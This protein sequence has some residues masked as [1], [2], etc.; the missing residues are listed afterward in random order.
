MRPAW[1]RVIRMHRR[2]TSANGDALS[3]AVTY[4]AL[5]GGVPALILTT[6]ALSGLGADRDRTAVALHRAADRLLPPDVAHALD[7]LRPD[8]IGLRIALVVALVW[9]SLRMVRA[10]RT[11]VR[12]MCGQNAG[13]GN[14]VRDAVVD[15]ALGVLLVAGA[16]AVVLA[17]ATTSLS[18][19]WRLLVSAPV[20][21]LLATVVMLRFSWPG[22]G[23]PT[24]AAAAR[25]AVG[26]AVLIELLTIAAAGY[27]RATANLHADIYRS[28]GALIGVLV[29]V[30][31]VSRVLLRAT[32]WAATTAKRPA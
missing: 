20:V 15:A 3:G 18:P 17:A 24:V 12:A 6:A 21:W 2:Y 27:F 1:D 29:W 16:A 23:R 22:E 4:G 13:S 25:S 8:S 30:S 5:I 7:A 9:S 11:G 19:P 28:A 14:P 26:A 31:L 10:L 32:A